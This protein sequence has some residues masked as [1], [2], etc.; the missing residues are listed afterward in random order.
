LLYNPQRYV[1]Y[2]LNAGIRQAGSDI[3]IRLDAHTTYAPDYFEQII[4]VFNQTDASIVGGPMRLVKGNAVQ[5]AIGYA[6]ATVFGIGN[7]SFHF[8][9]FEGYTNSV[10]LGAWKKEMFRTTGLFDEAFV[11]NQDDEFNYRAR[12]HGFSIYQSPAIKGYYH[13][14]KTFKKLFSQYFQYGFYKPMVLSKIKSGIRLSHV[15]PAMFILY[16]LLLPFTTAAAGIVALVPLFLY[17][18]L[19]LYFSVA[20]GQSL[21][22]I[23]HVC[24]VYPVLHIAYGS[25]FIAGMLKP[26]T[27]KKNMVA[28]AGS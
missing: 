16:L 14:R 17:L 3:I 8:Q 10:Y 9:A 28:L 19:I 6:T 4:A 13:P 5:N 15:I 23:L 21:V 11:R 2:A 27:Y 7:S 18:L 24:A 1:P 22:H 12:Q 25:G 26:L 20:A